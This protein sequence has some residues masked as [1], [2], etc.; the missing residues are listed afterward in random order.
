MAD[1]RYCTRRATIQRRDDGRP[2]IV[3]YGAV[4]YNASDPGTEYEMWPGFKERI[5]RGAFDGVD[6][7]T[8][9]LFNHDGNQVL[10]RK[11]AGTLRLSVD[12]VGLRY[13]IDS[14]D[15]Q[16]G[17]DVGTLIERGDVTGSS[18]SFS[19]QGGQQ[20][21]DDRSEPGCTIRTIERVGGLYDVGPVTFPAYSSACTGI[22][23]AEDAGEA[24]ASLDAY[25]REQEA[26]AV[27][28]R[29]LDLDLEMHP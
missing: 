7:D 12:D 1:R 27:K 22:R 24:Q 25:R 18:F 9:A 2:V 13:E 5:G 11:S 3:G 26:V 16:Q 28:M 20:S 8:R 19:M 14:P 6:D 10:G 17:R 29:L 15:T 23:S 21:H 4:F